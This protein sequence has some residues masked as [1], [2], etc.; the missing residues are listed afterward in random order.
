MP[1]C[2]VRS[3]Q[4]SCVA[5]PRLELQ[6]GLVVEPLEGRLGHAAGPLLVA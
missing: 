2:G 5:E 1:A 6:C 3:F 4:L